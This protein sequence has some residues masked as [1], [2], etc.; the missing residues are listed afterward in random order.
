MLLP[1]TNYNEIYKI[2]QFVIIN[3]RPS[4]TIN[5]SAKPISCNAV[6]RS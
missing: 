1:Q 5:G 3:N 6:A 2:V 4:Q